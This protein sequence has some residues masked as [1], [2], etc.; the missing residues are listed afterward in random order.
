MIP[1]AQLEDLEKLGIP[2]DRT[3]FT[4]PLLGHIGPADL[5]LIL[6]IATAVGKAAGDWMTLSNRTFTSGS[7]IALFNPGG[8]PRIA[9]AGEGLDV[10]LWRSYEWKGGE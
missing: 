8:G 4:V 10:D 3:L 6:G 7:A 5:Y 2:R 1:E 9:T